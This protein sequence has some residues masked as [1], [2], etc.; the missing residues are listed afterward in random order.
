MRLSNWSFTRKIVLFGIFV[1]L[2]IN[3]INA[4]SP[5]PNADTLN[6]IMVF[7]SGGLAIIW[8]YYVISDFRKKAQQNKPDVS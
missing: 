4:I 1:G 5:F 8:F 7:V 3:V 6:L 2:V